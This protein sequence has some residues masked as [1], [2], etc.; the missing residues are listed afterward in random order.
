MNKRL[1]RCSIRMA[2]VKK[3]KKDVEKLELWCAVGRNINGTMLL[4]GCFLSGGFPESIRGDTRVGGM[5]RFIDINR[6]DCPRFSGGVSAPPHP[7]P[8]L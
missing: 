3:K 8:T 7:H 2:I 1:K 6:K 5:V 4:V